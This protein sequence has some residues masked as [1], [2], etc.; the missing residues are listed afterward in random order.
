[1]YQH[2]DRNNLKITH[3][4]ILPIKKY[5]TFLKFMGFENLTYLALKH[6][7]FIYSESLVCSPLTEIQTIIEFKRFLLLM[8][9][10]GQ[11]TH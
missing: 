6:P 2:S 8:G 7:E 1:M 11:K 4:E 5:N 9:I 3:L 10:E